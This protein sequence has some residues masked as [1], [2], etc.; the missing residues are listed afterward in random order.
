MAPPRRREYR[1]GVNPSELRH[2]LQTSAPFSS[3]SDALLDAL[4]AE[5]SVAKVRAGGAVW[6]EGDA[7][8]AFTVIQHGLVAIRRAAAGGEDTLLGIFG[9]REAIGLSAV[10]ERGVYP[11][12]AVA[13]SEDVEVIRVRAAPVLEA[14]PHD[15][16]LAMGVN[17]ALLAHTRALRSKIDVMS[18]GPVPRRLAA[19][20]L[21]LADR[22]GDEDETGGLLV[23]VGISRTGLAR[24]VGARPETV[25][26]ALST[27]RRSRLLTD[28]EAGTFRFRSRR[29]LEELLRA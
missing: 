27:W 21:H 11:A 6:R 26:R 15:S 19:L 12:D 17:D 29:G 5:A 7:A 22:F 2:R 16:A 13:L 14:L 10:L 28:A 9:P 20:F 24:L 3:A 23:P 18:A 8:T 1:R 25:M 4:A